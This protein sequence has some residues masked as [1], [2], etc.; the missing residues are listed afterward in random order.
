MLII[1]AH[2]DTAGHCGEALKTVEEGLLAKGK[3]YEVLDLYAT[4]FDPILRPEEM[5]D[6]GLAKTDPQIREIQEKII[7]EREYVFIYPTWWSNVPA[8]LKGFY[9]RVFSSGFAFQYQKNG[10]PEGLLKGKHA[11]VITTSGG[12]TFYQYAVRL[13]R[14][15]LVTTSDTLEFCGVKT[16]N[17]L[18]GGCV[19]LDETK[20]NEIKTKVTRSLAAFIGA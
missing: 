17:L 16:K 12:P 6:R 18:I 13:R 11:L 4:G 15:I 20:K 1:Y 9:D 14:S 10:F 8:I 19:K 5:I 2:F 3:S 7:A